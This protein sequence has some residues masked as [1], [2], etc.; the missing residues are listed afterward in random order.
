MRSRQH[1]DDTLD[2]T[3]SCAYCGGVTLLIGAR[4]QE[5]DIFAVKRRLNKE[6]LKIFY[7]NGINVPFPHVTVMQKGEE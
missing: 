3:R 2:D 4:C 5:D 7:K 6:V 1:C